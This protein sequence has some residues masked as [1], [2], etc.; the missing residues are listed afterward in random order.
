[1][2]RSPSPHTPWLPLRVLQ[3][4]TLLVVVGA[5]SAASAQTG[6]AGST[7]TTTTT[8]L[9]STDFFIGVQKDQGVNLAPFDLLRF[10]NK[11]N[12]DCDEPVFMYV[13]LTAS[14]FAKKLTIG[15]GTIE[16]WVGTMCDN[17]TVRNQTCR[18][19][20]SEPLVNFM[21][22]GRD[23]IPTTAR[24]VSTYNV[25]SVDDAGV[26]TSTGVFEPTT[27]CTLPNGLTQFTPSFYVFVDLAADGSG[28]YNGS[29]TQ[30]VQVDLAP[31]PAPTGVTV[32]PGNEA[33]TLHW[34]A[35][36]F[37]LNQDLQGYQI[38]C[39][40]G[41]DLQVFPTGTFTPAFKTCAAKQTGT[42]IEGLDPLFVCSD[43]LSRSST[44]NRVKILQNG[45]TYAAAVV[46]IDISGNASQPVLVD[47]DSFAIPEKTNSF[48]EVYRNGNETNGGPG[49][50]PTPGAATGGFCAVSADH[51]SLSWSWLGGG[52]AGVL[53]LAL[54]LRRR[55][56]S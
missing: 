52:G 14:G 18:L 8:S 41:A 54:V 12:C 40:R 32:A 19:L 51:R 36:D 20:K 16:F 17:T 7:G 34:T 50:T 10:F 23:T 3:T 26:T 21:T 43:L 37:S 25:A 33:I 53:A 46:S 47:P 24:I 6:I 55:R 28:T 49:D 48:Y 13:S 5:A 15:A 1:V 11:A 4:L 2:S 42:D 30:P 56:K 44:S 27:T 22:Q 31:P 45:I 9:S 38:L 29:A 35:V 39:R